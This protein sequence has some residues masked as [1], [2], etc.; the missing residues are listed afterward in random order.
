MSKTA[1]EVAIAAEARS[2]FGKGAARRLRRAGRIP[3]VVYGKGKDLK[4]ISLPGHE[5]ELALRDPR[6]VLV[7]SIDG[8]SLLT[9]AQEIQRDPVRRN[10]EHV[11]LVVID[12]TE[13][14]ARVQAGIA[15]AQETVEA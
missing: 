4:H 8:A 7:V 3:A 10:L 12:R 11:D 14:D 9:R 5:L 6:V 2:D 1:G 15:A 13:A